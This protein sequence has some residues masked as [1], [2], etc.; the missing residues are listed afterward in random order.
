MEPEKDSRS[1]KRLLRAGVLPIIALG[2]LV[3]SVLQYQRILRLE[4]QLAAMRPTHNDNSIHQAELEKPSQPRQRFQPEDTRL[5]QE[6]A[7]LRTECE[8]LRRENDNVLKTNIDLTKTTDHLWKRA[9]NA[10]QYAKELRGVLDTFLKQT[11]PDEYERQQKEMSFQPGDLVILDHEFAL[12]M[13]GGT[14]PPS[15]RTDWENSTD[16]EITLGPGY[17]PK[18]FENVGITNY[19]QLRL[20]GFSEFRVTRGQELK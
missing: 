9:R 6:L 1:S 7:R 10:S 14:L 20:I 18:L 2:L 17:G 11:S 4:K 13:F 12:T 8:L 15:M 5:K 19:E 16:P 3:T